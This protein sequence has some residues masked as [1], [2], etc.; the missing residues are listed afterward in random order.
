MRRHPTHHQVMRLYLI[1]NLD[2]LQVEAL[3]GAQE[4]RV[5][6]KMFLLDPSRLETLGSRNEF[7]LFHLRIA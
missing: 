1:K 4:A 5:K 2:L 6:A 7:V 3:A